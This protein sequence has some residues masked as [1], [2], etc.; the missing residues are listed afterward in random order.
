MENPRVARLAILATIAIALVCL[1]YFRVIAY[2]KPHAPKPPT[3]AVCEPLKPGIRRLGDPYGFQFDVSVQD[4]SI[5]EGTQDMPPFAHGFAAIPRNSMSALNISY[6]SGE[7]LRGANP[8]PIFTFSEHWEKRDIIND[9]RQVVGE[10]YWGYLDRQ[11]IWRRIHL[12]G[13]VNA[14]YDS[15]NQRDAELFDKVISS[16]CFLPRRTD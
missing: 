14:R 7:G 11:K 1:G 4:F 15:V 13:R 6:G 2:K 10:D 8:D 16:A 5:V 3:I 9:K 12:K